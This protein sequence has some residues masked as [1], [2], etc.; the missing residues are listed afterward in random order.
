MQACLPIVFAPMYGARSAQAAAS[1]PPYSAP[2]PCHAGK[3]ALMAIADA[4]VQRSDLCNPQE[5]SNSGEPG[6]G[7]ML[8]H[9]LDGEAVGQEQQ[10]S[11]GACTGVPR[12]VRGQARQVPGQLGKGRRGAQPPVKVSRPPGWRPQSGR[13]P[14]WATTTAP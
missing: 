3:A 6:A 10:Q 9:L 5:V 11:R 8:L 13:L 14:S 1:L 12:V 2:T 7:T 4:L